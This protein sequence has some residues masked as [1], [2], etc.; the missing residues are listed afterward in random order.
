MCANKLKQMALAVLQHEGARREYP[1]G[2]VAYAAE[3]SGQRGSN[4]ASWH[5]FILPYAEQ[6]DL[7][8]KGAVQTGETDVA[9]QRAYRLRNDA[10]PYLRCPSDPD[11]LTGNKASTNYTACR[12][13]CN[14]AQGDGSCTANWSAYTNRPDLGWNAGTY[15]DGRTANGAASS[16]TLNRSNIRGMFQPILYANWSL[17]KMTPKD[18]KDGTGKTIM[19][20]ETLPAQ[21]RVMEGNAYQAWGN[22]P[23]VTV[24]PI[25]TMVKSG[26]CTANDNLYV[27]NWGTATGFKSRHVAGVNFA[28]GDGT[29]RFVSE[30]VNMDVLQMLG[31][32][33]D[34]QSRALPT[35]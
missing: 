22:Y 15:I 33:M 24:I 13:P 26:N 28:F 17:W 35:E 31:H 21:L 3:T 32:P 18:M 16:A 4:S 23:M 14:Y 6:I 20:G 29:V 34:G 11:V 9:A 1:Q 2:S 25:N 27:Q 7:Y 5:Y 12:G 19:L 10:T 30:T 8:T